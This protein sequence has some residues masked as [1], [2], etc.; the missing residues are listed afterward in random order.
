MRRASD[1]KQRFPTQ[2]E[3][4]LQTYVLPLAD[5]VQAAP[6]LDPTHLRSVRLVFDRLVAGTIVVDDIGV[7][8]RAG[9]FVTLATP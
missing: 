4:V 6:G 7:S 1:E 2:F 3:I 5:F 8:S 9:P